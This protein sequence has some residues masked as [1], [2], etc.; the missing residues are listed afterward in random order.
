MKN[1]CANKGDA[2][3]EAYLKREGLNRA[4]RP[5]GTRTS[6][7][8]PARQSQTNFQRLPWEDSFSDSDSGGMYF[9][10]GMCRFSAHDC[11]ELLCQGVKPWDDDAGAV[12]GALH[13][14]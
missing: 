11:D 6:D 13:G 1:D 12:L 9:D 2:V 14:W 7:D 10:E 3:Q 4:V 5:K 8:R